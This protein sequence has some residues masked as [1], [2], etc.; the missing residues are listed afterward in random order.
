MFVEAISCQIYGC[1]ERYAKICRTGPV[2]CGEIFN[3]ARTDSYTLTALT[4]LP[5]CNASRESRTICYEN[6]KFV[7]GLS[8]IGTL[9]L[10]TH[11]FCNI[12][13]TF[14]IFWLI[15][16]QEYDFK[17]WQLIILWIIGDLTMSWTIDLYLNLAEAIQTILL[18]SNYLGS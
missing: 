12:F 6:N 2:G 1:C 5:F 11:L 10:M 3:L 17:Y 14:L 7:G 8:P 13:Q 16:Y 4:G 9:R 15:L 18:A